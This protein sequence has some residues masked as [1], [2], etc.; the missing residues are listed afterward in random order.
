MV[1]IIICTAN[2]AASLRQTLAAMERVRVPDDLDAELLVVDN[3][4]T[5]H[6]ALVARAAAPA[7]MPV[8][9]VHEPRRGQ[10][11]ARNRG[12]A[13]SAGDVVL[14]TDDDVRPPADWI[15]GMCR[16]ILD[17]E[18]D[19]VAGGVVP[20]PHLWRPWLKELGGW[21]ACT[22]GLDPNEPGRMVGANMAFSRRVLERVPG[23][24]TELGPGT[25][26]FHDD[27]L[28]SRQLLRAGYRIAGRLDVAVEHHFDEGRLCAR[29]FADLA[30]RMGR[31][32]AYVLHHWEH[33]A[34]RHPRAC[35]ARAAL[36][37]AWRRVRYAGRW[38]RADDDGGGPLLCRLRSAKRV[39]FLRQYLRERH[40]PR[41]YAERGLAKCGGGAARPPGAAVG[42]AANSAA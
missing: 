28:F 2:R 20:A 36:G 31:S 15:E 30:R 14:F 35:L 21:V 7:N 17:G 18:A 42:L 16:P 3:A 5:D 11:H 29:Q 13:E 24:D 22:N 19:A 34:V 8:R 39:A 23:F 40:R 38:D 4:S 6:T 37:L 27:T 41:N 9:L 25:L 1:S 12:L 33:G 32:D 10:C 26:G